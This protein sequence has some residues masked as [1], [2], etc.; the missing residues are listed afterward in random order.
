MIGSG[1]SIVTNMKGSV[2]TMA[3]TDVAPTT[4]GEEIS[5]SEAFAAMAGESASLALSREPVDPVEAQKEIVKRILAAESADQVLGGSDAIHARDVLDV[6]FELRGVRFLRSSF[7]GS[8]PG[9]FA[10]MD[11]V[12]V[13]SGEVVA[14][15]CGG[16]NVMAQAAKLA[17]LG[18][19]PA[20]VKIVESDRPTAAGY[21]PMWLEAA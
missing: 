18:S 16:L 12:L 6:P 13:T 1:L 9:I 3:K 7:E 15:T 8:G 21:R 20:D 11:A 2:T 14:I 19:L 17:Q 10:V 5:L 4:T